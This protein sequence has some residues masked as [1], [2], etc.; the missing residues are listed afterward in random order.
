M[1]GLV[2]AEFRANPE[3]VYF[4]VV[5][6]EATYER[7]RTLGMSSL[8]AD[9]VGEGIH[10]R[11]WGERSFYGVDPSGNPICFV[12]DQTLFTGASASV[13]MLTT[14]DSELA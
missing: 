2:P 9:D 5:D 7:A 10:T 13:V 12:D 1:H 3:L 4:A 8:A 11:P 14:Y 6:L